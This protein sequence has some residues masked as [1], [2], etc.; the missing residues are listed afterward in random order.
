MTNSDSP[1][2]DESPQTGPPTDM[3]SIALRRARALAANAA[4]AGLLPLVDQIGEGIHII[5][6]PKGDRPGPPPKHVGP[7]PT[8]AEPLAL[9][10]PPSDDEAVRP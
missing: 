8:A 2:W 1:P 6:G 9:A 7:P 5:V 3:A 10:P 4:R